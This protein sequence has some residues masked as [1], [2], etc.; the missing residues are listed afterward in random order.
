MSVRHTHL[1]QKAVQL[2]TEQNLTLD[3]LV[4]RLGL[5]RT[6][7]YYWIKDLP[8]PRT[9]RQSEARQRASDANRDRAKANRDAAYN[10]GW[11]E[12]PTLLADP[13]FRDFVVL[14]IGEGGKKKRN[15]VEIVNSDPA[16]VRVA[17]RFIRQLSIN[18]I[19]YRL[20]YHADHDP[21]ALKQFWGDL[22]GIDPTLVIEMRKSNSNQLTGR[23]FRSIHGLLT[24]RVGDTYLRARLQAWMDFVKSQW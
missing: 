4:E 11:A 15:S 17:E 24:V 3:E 19:E 7:I 9:E 23:S 21:D 16:I 12:A 8:I 20:Q 13:V 2:R 18:K 6:T 14:Y 10:Q 5:P 1:R 22:L